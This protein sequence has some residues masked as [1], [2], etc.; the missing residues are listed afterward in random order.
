MITDGKIERATAS[1]ASHPSGAL[2]AFACIGH[3]V[4]G[5]TDLNVSSPRNLIEQITTCRF[6]LILL[7]SLHDDRPECPQ[8]PVSCSLA[9]PKGRK[10]GQPQAREWTKCYYSITGRILHRN[11][12]QPEVGCRLG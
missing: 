6:V 11:M 10:P 1:V 3:C 4:D 12:P 9:R 7:V 5:L 8:E 2:D